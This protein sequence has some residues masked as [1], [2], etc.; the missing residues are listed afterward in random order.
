M[1]AVSKK[2]FEQMSVKQVVDALPLI[3]TADGSPIGVL[4]KMEDVIVIGDMHPAV[5]RQFR[6]KETLVRRGMPP[7]AAVTIDRIDTD[8]SVEQE[9]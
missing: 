6:A 7:V 5:K 4:S 1:N 8:K 2:K 9:S 3:I